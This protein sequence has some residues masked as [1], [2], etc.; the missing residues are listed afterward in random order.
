MPILVGIEI[1]D[2]PKNG[3]GV[4]GGHG[5]LHSTTLPTPLIKWKRSAKFISNSVHLRI[6]IRYNILLILLIAVHD[7]FN[8][9]FFFVNY[10]SCFS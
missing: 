2:L 6:K 9:D 3:G 7:S 4:G 1:T 10:N 8:S 5:P